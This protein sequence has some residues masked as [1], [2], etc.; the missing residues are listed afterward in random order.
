MK[1]KKEY[2]V[3]TNDLRDKLKA[4]MQNE[5]ETLPETLKGLDP[6]QRLNILCKLL[7]FVLPKVESVHPTEGEPFEFSNKI[8]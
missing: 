3:I 4:M 8:F 2:P 5:L 7:P 1:A 6:V